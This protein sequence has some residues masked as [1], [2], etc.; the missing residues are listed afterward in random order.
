MIVQQ[1]NNSPI[2]TSVYFPG[3]RSHSFHSLSEPRLSSG[4][5]YLRPLFSGGLGYSPMVVRKPSPENSI[6]INETE[7][8]NIS[9]GLEG[10]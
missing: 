1:S 9:G 8:S 10:S 3:S 5:S 6:H 4:N 7:W 2:I